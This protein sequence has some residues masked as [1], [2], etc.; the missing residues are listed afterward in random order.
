MY[1]EGYRNIT[2]IDFSEIVVDDMQTK[3]KK[4][5]YEP[6]MTCT[7]CSIGVDQLADVR[8]M[9][10]K[11]E[12]ESFDCIIDKGL[13]DSILVPVLVIVVWSILEAEFQE[14]A[15]RDIASAEE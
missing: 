3:Y 12:D 14:N 1:K 11:F 4:E 15:E 8:N 10:G 2:N 13:L 5:G 9:R 7:P 6:T